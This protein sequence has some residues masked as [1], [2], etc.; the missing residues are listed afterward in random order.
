MSEELRQRDLIKN[1]PKIKNWYFYNIGA[2]NLNALKKH[3][4]IPSIDYGS[5]GKRKP[6]GLISLN[7]KVI[8]VIENKLPSEFNTEK[9][10]AKAI[11][12]S[13]DLAVALNASILI[14]TDTIDTIWIN[15]KTNQVIC[16]E[17]GQPVIEPFDPTSDTTGNLIKSIIDSIDETN[18]SIVPVERKDPSSLAKQIW[19]D[20]WSVSGATPENCLYT[21][22]ELFIF[23]YLSDLNVLTGFY[24]FHELMK[25][26]KTNSNEEVLEFYADIIRKE[27]K[28]KFKK[29]DRDNTTII[30][31]T[32][33]VSKDEK[34]VRG[35]STVFRKIL[36]KFEKEGRLENI[37]HDFKS[38]LFESFL[39]E[40]ISKKNW[41]QYFTPLKVVSAI[42]D[43]VEIKEGMKICDPAC[44]VGK[45]LLEPVL[46]KIERFYPVIDNKMAPKIELYGYDKGFDHDEQKTIIL[47]KANMLIYFSDIIKENPGLS[48]QFSEL[49]NKTFLLKTNSILG[50]LSD[51]IVDKFDLI[52]TN[53]PYVTSG[54][55]NLKEE[56]LKSGLDDHFKTNSLGVEGLFLEWII[57]AL[58]PGGKAF[59]V[60]P[61][62][63]FIRK[64]D[65]EMRSFIM[66]ECYVDAI[67]SLPIKTFFTTNKKTFILAITKKIDHSVEQIEP[68]FTY[69]VSDIGESLDINRFDI[70]KND[71]EAGVNLF[72][73]FKGA[74]MHFVSH[75]SR[76]K[77]LP[78]EELKNDASDGWFIDE[79]WSKQERI[80]LGILEKD[81]LLSLEDFSSLIGEVSN[82][83]TEYQDQLTQLSQK[84]KSTV[85]FKNFLVDDLFDASLGDPK[86]T[87]KY[88][89]THKGEHPVYSASNN[90][91]LGYMR[92]YDY[93]CEAISWARNG[94]AG[95]LTIHSGKFSVNYDRGLLLP[96]TDKL[97][98]PYIHLVLEP[99]LRN[100]ARGRK[101]L[102]GKDEFTKVYLSTI[103]NIEIPLPVDSKG[104]I[105]LEQ[106]VELF[107]NLQVSKYLL[108]EVHSYIRQ[109]KNL[110][111]DL[112]DDILSTK[113]VPILSIF[114]CFKGKACYT[115]KY[116][117]ENLGEHPVYSSQTIEEGV[118]GWV[119][120]YD[121]D[122][123]YIT[124]TTDGIHAGTPFLRKGKF[125][126]STHCGALKLKAEFDEIISIEYVYFYLKSFLKYF[127]VGEQNKRLTLTIMDRK[128]FLPIPIDCDGK[129]DLV[130]QQEI[131]TKMK[132]VEQ[133]RSLLISK[134]EAIKSSNI[135]Y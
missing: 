64:Y 99:I 88:I 4:I 117:R 34:A 82:S 112:T 93:D 123:E 16:N 92:T 127:A 91:P 3:G 36:E 38:K 26:Y 78:F 9:K 68:I 124:W 47:A 90:G 130:K 111:I 6:D 39:K 21:F 75:D 57:R 5:L 87:R 40:S 74:K 35:Y 132:T 42:V 7:Q 14:V 15:P 22:V 73:Q 13:Y 1:P 18:S 113:E 51:P 56:V 122:G 60:V 23:K 81:E 37:H 44:G 46:K 19:Q 20:I 11:K 53:P 59:I 102:D 109:I 43:M 54:S 101:S 116:I 83:L 62:G 61:D 119:D 32:I 115:K 58:K 118:I 126:M 100:I 48:G 2:T 121:Y 52:L 65:M 108:E 29:S 24:N 129:F 76:C 30:N 89:D 133:I 86:F 12:Q 97:Y 131:V 95:Y 107:K 80:D 50:T 45:F 69:L 31:G 98:L 105:S 55:S 17:D 25:Q 72:N 71:L 135:Q 94:F 10:R 79:K 103:K 106:Q 66:K 85:K 27:I 104:K 63:L 110:K 96:S 114:D 49:F 67:I 134:L 28:S 8:A 70:D 77:I 128:V 125:S 84:K 33:F 120:S 41:G